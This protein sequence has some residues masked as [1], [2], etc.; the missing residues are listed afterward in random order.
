M[1]VYPAFE[2]WLQSSVR[3]AVGKPNIVENQTSVSLRDED[4]LPNRFYKSHW[5]GRSLKLPEGERLCSVC[6][7]LGQLPSEQWENVDLDSCTTV[8]QHHRTVEA[9]LASAHGGCHFCNLIVFAWEENYI[10]SKNSDGHWVGKSDIFP[11]TV[12]MGGRIELIFGDI[13]PP[14]QHMDLDDFEIDIRLAEFQ[15]FQT[16]CLPSMVDTNTGSAASISKMRAW[17]ETYIHSHAN[18]N[19]KETH[20]PS[21]PT[22]V[23][24]VGVKESRIC[25]L[26]PGADKRGDYAALSHCW[27][28][29]NNQ[30]LKTTDETL[31]LRQQGMK[32]E[33]LP[34][35]FR[36]AVQVCREL[37]IKYLWV[38]SLCII[39][40]QD[41]Q[42][43][44]ARRLPKWEMYM[45][46]QS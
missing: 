9:L 2:S 25:H 23:I 28:S 37:G 19:R 14:R 15:T 11:T 10:W 45:E 6:L 36:D 30:P 31:T 38:D 46:T 34:K 39:Q 35:T 8:V 26:V 12:A 16:A 17:L 41:S 22:R 27:G 5:Q 32:D 3:N 13:W 40:D 24:A 43:D 42:E 7:K 18:C 20:P 44:W 29:S 1:Q 33:E 4:G 21:L